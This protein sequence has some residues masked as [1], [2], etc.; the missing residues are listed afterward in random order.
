MQL[1]I[2]YESVDPTHDSSSLSVNGTN[3]PVSTSSSNANGAQATISAG[4]YQA[5]SD[6]FLIGLGVDYSPIAGA[7]GTMAVTT[8]RRLPG[9]NNLTNDYSYQKKYS[10]NIFIS[11]A[12][13]VGTNG[14]AYA[15]VGYSGAKV[16][17]YN[18]LDYNFNGYV[19]G[20]GYRHAFDGGWFAFIEGNYAKYG[21]QTES[22]TNT[23]A[24]GRT[25]TSSGTN[26][27]QTYNIMIGAGY[28]F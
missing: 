21:N 13:T 28:K 5:V 22:A 27:L 9:Q 7:S 1:G 12:V 20:L 8:E 4:W 15:K 18:S 2:G 17:N 10:Y 26:G 16:T 19:L 3:I 11:P 14:M 6:R 24:R 23:V 25:L